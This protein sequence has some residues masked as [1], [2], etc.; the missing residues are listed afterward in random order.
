MKNTKCYYL[1]FSQ[2]DF[3]ENQVIEELIR[4]RSNYYI[5]ENKNPDFWVLNSPQFIKEEDI[6]KKIKNS[7]FYKLKNNQTIKNSKEYYSSILTFNEEFYIWM[8]LRLGDFEDINSQELEINKIYNVD[9]IKGYFDITKENTN[10]LNSDNSQLNPELITNK[11]SSFI[12][13]V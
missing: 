1:I 7:N 11:F 6:N 8:Q 3:L 5:S 13:Y 12:Q 9:G 10:L 4:E 2:K